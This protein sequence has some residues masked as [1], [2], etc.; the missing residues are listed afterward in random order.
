[1]AVLVGLIWFI[2][3][4][5][6]FRQANRTRAQEDQRQEVIAER[7][8]LTAEQR[9]HH[10]AARSLA[11]G[12]AVPAAIRLRARRALVSHL[13]TAIT[14]DARARIAHKQLTGR[15]PTRTVCTPLVRNQRAGDELDLGRPVGRFSCVAVI[16]EV[17]AGG[18]QGVLFG[19]PFVASVDFAR[20]TY[21]WCKDNPAANAAETS[22]T[23]AFVRLSRE[24]LAAKG[25]SFR[26]GYVQSGRR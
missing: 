10:G 5:A 2:P 11:V 25:R 12:T 4:I 13:Q 21:V 16:S 15:P 17:R 14:V 3:Q 19:I 23:L 24:C 20:A 6:R 22:Q 26:S 7:A 9:P 8:R 18:G 1:M